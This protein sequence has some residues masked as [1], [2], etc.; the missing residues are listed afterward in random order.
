MPE[1]LLLP[2]LRLNDTVKPPAEGVV[3]VVMVDKLAVD[4]MNEETIVGEE[5][6][7]T[8]FDE[9]CICFR[10]E[11]TFCC[12]VCCCFSPAAGNGTVV[13]VAKGFIKPFGNG[14]VTGN[15][16]GDLSDVK[17]NGGGD[18]DSPP[19]NGPP[20]SDSGAGENGCELVLLVLVLLP[21]CGELT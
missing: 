13:V 19:P 17:W 5:N 15:V 20:G 3:V 6:P 8:G 16:G 21:L 18:I 1:L 7:V 9:G 14:G 4:S 11:I 12:C 2:S 10:G